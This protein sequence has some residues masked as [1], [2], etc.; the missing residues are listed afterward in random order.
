MAQTNKPKHTGPCQNF[1]PKR[2]VKIMKTD[3][4]S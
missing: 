2:K 1:N 4:L 3:K